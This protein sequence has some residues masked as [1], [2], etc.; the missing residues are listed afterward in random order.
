MPTGWEVKSL[1]SLAKIILG[2]SPSSD[3]NYKSNIGL[4]LANGAAGYKNGLIVPEIYTSTPTRVCTKD[5]MVFCIRATIGNLTHAEGDYCLGRSVA[6]VRPELKE[7]HEIIYYALDM[8][9]ETFKR[10]AAGSIIVGITKEDLEQMKVLVPDHK[11]IAGFHDLCS[12]I[13]LRI[14]LNYKETL[15]LT[16]LRD[17]LLPLLINGEVSISV[18]G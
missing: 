11:A 8:E 3:S 14:R 18:K 2:Q 1:V 12:K 17:F 16:R 15:E 13:L 9:M 10:Q 6:A 4:P 7:L 5:D